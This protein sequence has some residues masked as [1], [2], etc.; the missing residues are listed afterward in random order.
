MQCH[1]HMDAE[2]SYV[3]MQP[4]S[5]IDS[6]NRNQRTDYT[7]ASEKEIHNFSLLSKV[8]NNN[9]KYTVKGV[10]DL[11]S[12]LLYNDFTTRNGFLFLSYDVALILGFKLSS[13]CGCSSR[14]NLF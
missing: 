5:Q 1:P 8:Q 4:T 2:P 11:Q 13:I 6:T 12:I 10:T 3:S 14:T 9:P 7:A